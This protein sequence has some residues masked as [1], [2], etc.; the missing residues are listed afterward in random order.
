MEDVLAV[1]RETLEASGVVRIGYVF[2][3]VALGTSR[4]G[5]DVDVAVLLDPD[6]ERTLMGPLAPM[7]R[8]LERRLARE[9]DLVLLDRAPP[10]LVHRV[11]A[12]G[13]LVYERDRALRIQFEVR[14]RNEYFDMLPHLQRYR[15][16][17]S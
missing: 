16:R 1:V 5:S 9:V 15:R 2:G 8:A 14:A 6:T 7:R 3:S 17:A 13:K 10:D 4:P 11:L 12:A